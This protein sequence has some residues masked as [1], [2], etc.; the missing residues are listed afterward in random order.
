MDRRVRSWLHLPDPLA[1]PLDGA[2]ALRC[3]EH[4]CLVAVSAAAE[5]VPGDRSLDAGIIARSGLPPTRRS[6]CPDA[7][8][9]HIVWHLVSEFRDR[10]S[11]GE[12]CS[13]RFR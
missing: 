1:D 3:R 12:P 9:I 7:A 13:F 4:V 2:P 5:V 6:G 10:A 11:R 8:E